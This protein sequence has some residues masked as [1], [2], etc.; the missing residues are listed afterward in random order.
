MPAIDCAI[1]ILG[2]E[3]AF[4]T[5][6]AIPNATLTGFKLSPAI[7]ERGEKMFVGVVKPNA[8]EIWLAAKLNP[9]L[10]KS[11]EEIVT[12]NGSLPSVRSA[13]GVSVAN[14]AIFCANDGGCIWDTRVDVLGGVKD[15]AR[16]WGGGAF[17]L[18]ALVA[19]ICAAVAT[20][21]G[22]RVGVDTEGAPLTETPPPPP[23]PVTLLGGPPANWAGTFGIALCTCDNC[24]D[25]STCSWVAGKYPAGI[26][27]CIWPL[28][29]ATYIV[30]PAEL[31]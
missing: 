4:T 23:L 21:C 19:L 15:A 27:P 24:W 22:E 2:W 20:A 1:A 9:V 12:P 8:L 7:E 6:F 31:M 26:S 18:G 10:A 3:G 11:E 16:A 17:T 25:T 5:A 14:P 29:L 13:L 28:T 30:F